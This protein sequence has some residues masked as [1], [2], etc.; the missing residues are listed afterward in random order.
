MDNEEYDLRMNWD[1]ENRKITFVGPAQHEVF[2]MSIR[3]TDLQTG[4]VYEVQG[5]QVPGLS[6]AGQTLH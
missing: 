4:C 6:S 5:I 3:V 2:D 1:P